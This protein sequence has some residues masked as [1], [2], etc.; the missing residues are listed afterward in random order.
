MRLMPAQTFARA[1]E[2]FTV[3]RKLLY[4]VWQIDKLLFVGTVIAILIPAIIPFITAYIFKLIIDQVALTLTGQILDLNYLWLLFGSLFITNYIQR[5]AFTFQNYTMKIFYIKIPIQLNQIVLNKI[6]SL[7]IAHFEDSNFQDTLQKVRDNFAWRPNEMAY[8]VLFLLQ[9]LLQVL[10]ALYAIMQLNPWLALLIIIVAFPD[11]LNQVL[12]SRF[13]WN[14][15]NHHVPHRKKFGYLVGLLQRSESMK[16]LKIFATRTKF[17]QELHSIQDKF[18]K[19]NKKIAQKQLGVS[20]VFNLMDNVVLVGIGGYIVLEAIARRIT[21]GDISFYQTVISNFT[22]GIGGLIRNM[23][24]VFN[25]AQYIKSIF[26]VLEIDSIVKQSQ[27][28]IKVDFN[29]TPVIEFKNVS[30]RYPQTK[31]YVFKDFN[32]TINP[33]EKIALVGENGAGKT[34]LIKLLARFYDVDEGEILIDGVNLKELE[35]ETWYKTFG[36]LFQDFIKYEYPVKDNIYFG[37]VW[38]KED[39]E[40]IIDA[41]KSAGAHD[42]IKQ[43]ENEYSQM[44]GKTFEAGLDLSG[45]QWQKIALSRAF[46]RNA[47]LL[48]LDEPTSAIDAKAESEIFERVEKLSKDKSVIIISH[49]F[50]TVRNADKIYVIE[51][52]RIKE[53]GSHNELIKLNGQYATL[54]NLQAKGYQ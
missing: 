45:G 38:E 32:L 47:P 26:D 21:L 23:S 53:S 37:K 10:I 48:V 15:W 35:L 1:S 20:S 29:K 41:A 18:F 43:F 5:L 12:F 13:A 30:F 33:G 28:P 39:L 52:G 4:L 19:D 27:N 31:R 2:T 46:F 44:L 9:S 54:F 49:R 34:T 11:F 17:L 6:S 51:N 3:S 14:I 25:H 40:T 22:N 7:D 50:S 8:Q 16:E 36:V 42:M 24:N